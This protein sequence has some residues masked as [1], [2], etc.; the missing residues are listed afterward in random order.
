MGAAAY[1][2]GSVS[3]ARG[4][5]ADLAQRG[6]STTSPRINGAEPLNWSDERA[7]LQAELMNAQAE[8]VALKAR[9]AAAEARSR[10]AEE[11]AERSHRL[12]SRHFRLHM[13][14]ARRLAWAWRV[15]RAYVSPGLVQE[16][17]DEEPEPKDEEE[18]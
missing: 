3:V 15:I 16:F 8:I 7:R 12:A 1:R 5:A 2:R 4:V 18:A 11:K 14:A 17:R 13:A 10:A 9:E 6:Y